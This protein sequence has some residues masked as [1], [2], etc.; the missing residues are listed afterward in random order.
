MS[1]NFW[2][3]DILNPK[4]AM[5]S[6]VRAV[7]EPFSDGKLNTSVKDP[8]GRNRLVLETF[9]RFGDRSVHTL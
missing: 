5:Y 1:K 7:P 3:S 6:L 2:E 4:K 9:V 8:S